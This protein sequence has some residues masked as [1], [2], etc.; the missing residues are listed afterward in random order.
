MSILSQ[1]NSRRDDSRRF[2]LCNPLMFFEVCPE[3]QQSEREE[4]EC[5]EPV[6]FL[7]C[8]N[9]RDAEKDDE[10]RKICKRYVFHI[11][12]SILHLKG[13]R[14]EVGVRII[15][16]FAFNLLN[17]TNHIVGNRG[18]DYLNCHFEEPR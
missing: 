17:F 10:N 3:G 9:K 6:L 8:F 11:Y 18:E 12:T 14:I 7:K 13:E 16:V 2:C 5:D 4:K 1:R 15:V